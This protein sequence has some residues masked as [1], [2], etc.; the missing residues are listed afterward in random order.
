MRTFASDNCSGVAPEIMESIIAANNDHA[1]AYGDDTYTEEANKLIQ[2]TLGRD[3]EV[4]F[5]F[6]GTAANTLSLKLA[7]RSFS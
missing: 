4:V 5:V 7:T 6:S 3:A 1:I 2:E